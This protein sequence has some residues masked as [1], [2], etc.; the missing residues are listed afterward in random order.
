MLRALL[1]LR[2]TR[3][4]PSGSKVMPLEG[5]TCLLCARYPTLCLHPGDLTQSSYQTCKADVLYH[6]AQVKKNEKDQRGHYLVK[7]KGLKLVY[8]MADF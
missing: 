1:T 2:V 7:V 5:T 8:D 6:F 4:L 3:H